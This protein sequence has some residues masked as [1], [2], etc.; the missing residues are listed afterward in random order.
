LHSTVGAS[1]DI[2]HEVNRCT[3]ILK[4]YGKIEFG[5]FHTGISP[6]VILRT[7]PVTKLPKFH[8]R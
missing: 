2:A 7:E 4:S 1:V 8:T 6:I 3:E 5:A